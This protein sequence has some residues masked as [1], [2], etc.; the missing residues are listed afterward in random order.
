MWQYGI[1]NVIVSSPQLVSVA[2][3]ILAVFYYRELP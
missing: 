2:S 3:G 1:S